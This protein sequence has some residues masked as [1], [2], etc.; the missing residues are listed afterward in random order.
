M[1]RA[2]LITDL[3]RMQPPWVCVAGYWKDRTP[4]RPKLLYQRG[5]TENFLFQGTT[6]I[7]KPFSV[8][9]LDFLRQDPHPP[10]TED[11][12]IDPGFKALVQERLSEQRALAFLEEILDPD[13]ASIFG[14]EIFREPGY[15]VMAGT[16][17]RSLGTIRPREIVAV[18][19]T[20][21]EDGKWD[22]R[23]CFVDQSGAY[24][25]LAIT[26]L[27]FRYYCDYLRY[28]GRSPEEIERSLM[29]RWRETT[30]FL[31]IGLAR[32]WEKYPDRCYLQVTG[33][34]TFP[35]YLEGRCFADFEMPP[36]APDVFPEEEIPF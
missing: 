4:V 30:I 10:H 34:H 12:Y 28:S 13:V 24:Y 16:G 31:R 2:M 14:T 29:R 8:V 20:P 21:K 18:L 6:P 7:I 15:Y 26:D 19:Y 32:G 1:K 3:T 23:L 11:W 5:L 25:R 36:E 27:N 9:E 35:D 17:N 33:I 22:Y